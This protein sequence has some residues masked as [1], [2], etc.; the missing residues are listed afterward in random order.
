MEWKLTL[1][2]V[3][4][5]ANGNLLYGSGNSNGALYQLRRE[6]YGR[7]VQKGGLYVNLWQIH[8]EVWQKTTKFCKAVILQ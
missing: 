4:Q 1:P 8:V 2:Y 5:T 6:G 3:K 7:E